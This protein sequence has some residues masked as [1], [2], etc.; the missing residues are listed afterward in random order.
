MEK[1]SKADRD[2]H[3]RIAKGRA[4]QAQ[5]EAKTRKKILV[6]EV[7]ELMHAEYEAR[8]NMWAEAVVIA[9]EAVAKANSQIQ[10][11]C[12][13]LGIPPQHAPKVQLS[14]SRHS[15]QFSSMLPSEVAAKRDLAEHRVDA[16]VSMACDRIAEWV[17]GYEEKLLL[18]GMDSD[19]A[20][21]LAE[22]M[23]SV[24]EIMP[25]IG[26]DDIGVKHW[27]V[28]DD[29]AARLMEGRSTADWR[30]RKIDKALEANPG[31][32]ARAIARVV[33]MDHKTV[34]RRI[35][36]RGGES[37]AMLPTGGESGGESPDDDYDDH[38]EI[39]E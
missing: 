19:Q 37:P 10:L 34:L 39:D 13:E 25:N 12:L 9:E 35:G 20:R 29:A 21:A 30:N 15:G 17:R 6:N 31:A 32:S 11:R 18:E 5:K 7:L 28:D 24:A 16:M 38:D 36:E 33:G 23:P 8:D 1:M 4:T 14:W 3:I 22:S 26:L 27:Q 2:A